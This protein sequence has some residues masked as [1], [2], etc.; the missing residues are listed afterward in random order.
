MWKNYLVTTLRTIGRNKLF[1]F[2]NIIGLSIGMAA[3]MMIVFWVLDELSYDKALKNTHNVYRVMSYGTKYMIDGYSGTPM[4][5]AENASTKLPEVEKAVTFESIGRALARNQEEGFYFERGIVSDP[6]FFE[7]FPFPLKS[8]NPDHLLKNPHDIVI[9][10][11]MSRKFFKAENPV[12]KILVVEDIPMNVTGVFKS[13][14]ANSTLQL[15]FVAPYSLYKELGVVFSWGRFMGTTFLKLRE[16]TNPNIAAMKLTSMA[17]G[18]GCPQVRDGV[19]FTLQPFSSIHLDGK[20]NEWLPVYKSSDIRY[21]WLFSAVV[22]LILLI[23]CINYI[24]L[25]TARTDKRSFEIGMRKVSGASPHNLTTQFFAESIIFGVISLLIALSLLRLFWPFYQQ[26][27]GKELAMDFGNPMIIFGILAIFVLTTVL[28][29]LYPA[30]VLPSF[31]PVEVIK[32]PSSSRKGKGWMRKGLVVFQFFI[33]SLLIIS[34]LV[35]FRQIAFIRDTDMGFNNKNVVCIPMKENI[36]AKYRFMKEQLLRDPNIISVTGSDYL[37]AN[38]NNRCKGCVRWEGFQEGDDVDFVIPQVD[39]G[40]FETLEIPLV[41][42]RFFSP[43]FATDSSE[44][45]MIN[46]TAAR[47]MKLKNPVGVPC[48]LYGSSGVIRKGRIIGI[49]K[50]I[51]YSSLHQQI[52]PQF[53][54]VLRNPKNSSQRGVILVKFNS[55]NPTAVLKKVEEVWKQVNQLSPFEY[56]FLDQTYE[57]LYQ[58]DRHIG[59]IVSWFTILAIF[60][61]ALGTYGLTTFIAERR[62]KEVAI[63]KVN[64]ASFKKVIWLITSDFTRLVLAAFILAVPL[65]WY[66]MNKVLQVYAYHINITLWIIL[67]ALLLVVAIAFLASVSQAIKLSRMDPAKSIKYE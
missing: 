48:G 59:R 38:D 15:D 47:A 14:P 24:N 13:I 20:H 2:I 27:I 16:G 57:N 36:G 53:V 28:S 65:S 22:V 26:L 23:A 17:L 12:G 8:G 41:S 61:S 67:F 43:A 29:G 56:F 60:L 19:N 49:F 37:W 42:G 51:H 1:S 34:A 44:A 33:T 21:I 55:S 64:G 46:E 63:R 50:D 30:L 58:K 4:V 5:L 66:I 32:G 3:S 39:F 45:F 18:A 6:A 10:A 25:T 31:N 7:V 40:Y 52:D 54:R 35:L 11:E 62:T 9:S